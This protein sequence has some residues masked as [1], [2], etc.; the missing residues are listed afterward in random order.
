[1][2]EEAAT[3]SSEPLAGL[4]LSV[5]ASE[6]A[7][8]GFHWRVECQA[9][10]LPVLAERFRAA[11]YALEMQTAED[12][13]PDLGVLRLVTTFA[14]FRVVGDTQTIDRHLVVVDL[15]PGATAPSLCAHYPA[16]NW[17]EREIFD[18]FGVRYTDHPDLKR[19]LLPDDSD[20]HALL[21]DF[22]RIDGTGTEHAAATTTEAAH[23][24]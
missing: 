18:M 20:F 19:I 12:R 10:D 17:M 5:A 7:A 21:K 23:G 4:A 9:A 1:V 8:T 22:G 16:A 24:E 11:H 3:S 14:R 2:S 13:R 6:F 15:E